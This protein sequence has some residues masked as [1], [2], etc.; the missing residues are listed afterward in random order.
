MVVHKMAGM[1]LIVD[2]NLLTTYSYHMHG[3]PS[4]CLLKVEAHKMFYIYL[5]GYT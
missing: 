1:N 5:W 3:T 2:L 4:F